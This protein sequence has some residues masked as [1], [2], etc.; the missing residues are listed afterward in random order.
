MSALISLDIR[1]SIP[2]HSF[3][4]EAVGLLSSFEKLQKITLPRF[5]FTARIAECLSRLPKLGCIEFQY[6]NEQGCGDVTDI[7][8][9]KPD[10]SEGAFPVL[11]D[12]SMAASYSHLERFL[13]IPFSP[14]NLTMLYIES[15]NPETPIA[16]Q[17]LLTAISENCQMLKLLT[18]VSPR[19]RERDVDS[20][21]VPAR[22]SLENL[23]PLFACAN[24]TSLEIIHKY[25]LNLQLEDLELLA[26]RWPSL[27]TLNLNNE[28]FE[29]QTS[30]L[31]L[32]A[33][34]PFA[35]HCP[36]LTHLSVFVDASPASIP[37]F[38]PS[39][40]FPSF[41][42]L[43]RLSMGL[44]IITE[45]TPPAVF[46]SQILPLDCMVDSGITWDDSFLFDGDESRN[47]LD[48]R[49]RLWLNANNLIPVLTRVRVEERER[50]K[51]MRQELDDLQLRTR[52]L[53]EKFGSVVSSTTACVR[54]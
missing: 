49:Y 13:T 32:E 33:L 6:F 5:A 43:E 28:P 8:L 1:T 51:A 3:E 52:A 35:Q 27:E 22:I 24:L 15:P 29:F 31:T 11:W 16:I 45:P 10:L 14:S 53:T 42:C 37:P 26:V 39:S 30:K 21:V 20:S 44:S 25:P 12:L 4:G 7:A 17:Q 38:S 41:K 54:S 36:R 18:L 47:H 40:P 19:Q 50:A 46:L 9:F 2:M 34:F 23:K 48:D